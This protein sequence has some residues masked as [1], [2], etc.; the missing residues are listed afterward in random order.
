MNRP[1]VGSA[2]SR[3]GRPPGGPP[4]PVL[5]LSGYSVGPEVGS[6]CTRVFEAVQSLWWA[7]GSM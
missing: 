3:V 2:D 7:I 5:S 6:G 4:R 1:K